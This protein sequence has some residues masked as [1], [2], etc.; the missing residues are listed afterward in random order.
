MKTDQTNSSPKR[1]EVKPLVVV[2]DDYADVDGIGYQNHVQVLVEMI[3]SVESKGSFTIGVFGDWGQG[4]TS[5]LRQI[6]RT[7]D[8]STPEGQDP[9]LTVWFNP[10]QF[11]GEKHMIVPFFHTMVASLQAYSEEEKPW[12]EPFRARLGSFIK[13]LASVPIALAYGL[14]GEIKI[15][16]FLKAKF[17]FHR[18]I[19]ESRRAE[20]E[21]EAEQQAKVEKDEKEII[22]TYE[23]L[24]YTLIERL[25]VFAEDFGAKVVVFVDDLDRCLPEKAIEL[26]EGLK[27]LID[28][29]NFV[30]VIGVARQVIERGVRVRYKELY[31]G[32]KGDVPFL[33]HDYLDKIIQFP[34]TL[35]PPDEEKLRTNIT[36]HHLAQ[37]KDASPFMDMIH[38]ALG[39]NPRS[40]KRFL[41]AVSF[42]GRLAE[43]REEE[44]KGERDTEEDRELFRPELLIKMSL[45][46]F[47]FPDFYRLLG[48]S[49]R[50]LIRI[51]EIVWKLE[52]RETAAAEDQEKRYEGIEATGLI[53][54]DRLRLLEPPNVA[55]IA[56]VLRRETRVIDESEQPDQGFEDEEEVTR[57]LCMIAPAVSSERKESGPERSGD[58]DLWKVM[59]GRMVPIEG[60]Q[61]IMGDKETGQRE[62]TVSSFQMDQY[63]VTQALYEQV[64][65]ENPSRFKGDD[66]PAERVSWLDAVTF[67]NRLS[68]KL[69]LD[70]AYEIEGESTKW[71]KQS[72]GFRL[73][74]EAEW[75]YVS[76]AGSDEDRYGPI[77][78]IAWY[79]KNSEGTTQAVGQKAP[80]D[81][82]LHDMFGNVWE[83]CWN[84]YGKYRKEPEIDPVGP[85]EGGN[86]VMRGGSW[87][88][89]A[90]YCRSAY[91]SS[92]PPGDRFNYVGFRL[93]R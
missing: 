27:V 53:E 28:L 60:G 33:E 63:P 90:R 15:P 12:S 16:L 22:E 5:M 19:E 20:V 18:A 85:E 34:V 59:E 74:T 72:K 55:R 82:G 58:M 48:T 75:E 42:S 57:Y 93:Y 69:G 23:T 7:L 62:V 61:F 31:L 43:L 13:K 80:N 38:S 87:I 65:G 17:D 4:K 88:D 40:L 41:N 56:A 24:Y 36:E 76:R 78:E 81:F 89:V 45:I 77:D 83:W 37:L 3:L 9:A 8:E 10:W 32:D 21:I 14:E 25:R 84:R 11:A 6:K 44:L 64:M 46:A 47:Q 68:E 2:P 66:R 70:N 49:P 1:L 39:N 86:R 26:L 52:E 50:H 54:L 67:C 91:R 92:Y 79:R 71:N 51:Q 29:P 30:F 35:P 73:P